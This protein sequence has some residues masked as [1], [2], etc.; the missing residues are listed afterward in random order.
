M[1]FWWVF[2]FSTVQPI[3][4]FNANAHIKKRNTK[5]NIEMFRCPI[6]N[7]RDIKLKFTYARKPKLRSYTHTEEGWLKGELSNSVAD[8]MMMTTLSQQ[9]HAFFFSFFL[10]SVTSWSYSY[11]ELQQHYLVCLSFINYFII[12]LFIF[13]DEKQDPLVVLLA[14]SDYC[15]SI[16]FETWD[17]IS[18]FP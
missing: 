17:N 12:R 16:K 10:R 4:H 2:L 11:L 8:D 1:H 7:K 18:V 6:C 9:P 3:I 5:G 13:K 14:A 15:V